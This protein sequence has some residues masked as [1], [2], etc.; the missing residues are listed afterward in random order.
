MDFFF[1]GYGYMVEA[2]WEQDGGEDFEP[3][4]RQLYNSI[5]YIYVSILYY[6]IKLN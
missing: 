1:F 6:I 4:S 5:I 2:F 3:L